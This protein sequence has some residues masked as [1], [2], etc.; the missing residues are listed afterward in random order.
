MLINFISIAIPVITGFFF[1]LMVEVMNIYFVGQLDNAA[2]LAGI[3]I[4]NMYINISTLCVIIGLNSAL[5]T[6]IS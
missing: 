4:A 1:M 2:M 6:F 3:G 5:A